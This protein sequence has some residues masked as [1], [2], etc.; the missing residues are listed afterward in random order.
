MVMAI[1]ALKACQGGGV[2]VQNSQVIATLPFVIGGL[3]STESI[4]SLIAH[5]KAFNTICHEQLNVTAQFDPIMKLGA[6]PLDV[7]PNLRITDKGLVDV[8]KFEIIDIN[9]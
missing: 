8:T 7:I 1:D 4:D 2:A 6:M 3:M 5:Q 9:A